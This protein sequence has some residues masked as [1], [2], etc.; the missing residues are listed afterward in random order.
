M[1]RIVFRFLKKKKTSAKNENSG[2]PKPRSQK[3]SL[4]NKSSFM[5]IQLLTLGK[6]INKW[7][8]NG[9]TLLLKSRIIIF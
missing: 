4:E 5:A 3:K 7:A 8:Q 9:S 2:T 1:C 6:G